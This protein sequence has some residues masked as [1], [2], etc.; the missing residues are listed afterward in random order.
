VNFATSNSAQHRHNGDGEGK[1]TG[2]TTNS[3][4][5][6][7]AKWGG[8]FHCNLK[9]NPYPGLKIRGVVRTNIQCP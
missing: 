3:E 2:W 6:P 8:F 7:I 9:A 4:V 1:A 5:K